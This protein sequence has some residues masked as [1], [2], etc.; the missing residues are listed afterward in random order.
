MMVV[1]RAAGCSIVRQVNRG[2][3]RELV[4]GTVREYAGSSWGKWANIEVMLLAV[5]ARAGAI[6]PRVVEP[7]VTVDSGERDWH[8]GAAT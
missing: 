8:S 4:R 3:R 7:G 5:G 6:G 2:P 1:G